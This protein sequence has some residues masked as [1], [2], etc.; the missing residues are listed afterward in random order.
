LRNFVSQNRH[1]NPKLKINSFFLILLLLS[2]CATKTTQ[3]APNIKAELGQPQPGKAVLITYRRDLN[4]AHLAVTAL[5]NGGPF[6]ELGNHTYHWSYLEPGVHSL[7]TIWPKAA[8]IGKTTRELSVEA[9]QYYL[10]EMR[11]MGIAVAFKKKELNPSNTQL[12]TG[13]Y[14]QALAWLG[15]CC[16]LAQQA[17]NTGRPE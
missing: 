13:S 2:A 16:R 17:E 5:L 10:V 9:D 11:G 12:K 4:P 6:A 15:N 8:L 3:T 1:G 7:E 14:E